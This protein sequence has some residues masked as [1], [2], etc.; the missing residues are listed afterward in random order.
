MTDRE[1]ASVAN[2]VE[3]RLKVLLYQFVDLQAQ[4]SEAH[5]A[6]TQQREAVTESLTRLNEVIQSLKEQQSTQQPTILPDQAAIQKIVS[7]LGQAAKEEAQH[8]VDEIQFAAQ[9]ARRVLASYQTQ[10]LGSHWK[11]ILTTVFTTITTCFLIVWLLIP[12]PTL[13]LTKIQ[14]KELS[15]GQ[16]LH[17]LWPK[18]SKKEQDHLT[19]LIDQEFT[20]NAPGH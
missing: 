19:V 6:T 7:T 20:K 9:E 4:W 5:V 17:T 15:V 18:L 12:R 10:V 3:D 16:A 11:L 1:T 13:P 14:L 2:T 8:S